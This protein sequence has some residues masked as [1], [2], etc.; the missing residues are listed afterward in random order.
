MLLFLGFACAFAPPTRPV[1]LLVLNSYSPDSIAP[2]PFNEVAVPALKRKLGQSVEVYNEYLEL[3]RFPEEEHRRTLAETLRGRYRE[4]GI[5]IVVP[6]DFAALEFARQYMDEILPK[7]PV[8][9]V[10]VEARLIRGMTFPDNMTGVVHADDWRGTL[11]EILRMQPDTKEV[12]VVGGSAPIDHEYLEEQKRLFQ[13]YQSKVKFS[14]FTDLPLLEILDKVSKLPPHTVVIQSG[15]NWDSRGEALTDDGALKLIYQAAN[16]PVYALVGRNLGDGFV[17]GPVP[18]YRERYLLGADLIYRVLKGEQPAKI[19]IQFAVPEHAMAFDWRQLKRWGISEERLPAGSVVEF[20]EPSPWR[21]YRWLIALAILV[22]LAEAALIVGL[23]LQR[24]WGRRMQEALVTSRNEIRELAGR[25]IVAQEDERKRIA[26]ELH[27]DLSQQLAAVAIF[28]S[29]I[30]RDLST[31]IPKDYGKL[32]DLRGR[33]GLLHDGIHQLSHEL[34]PATLENAGLDAALR[35]QADE[36]NRLTGMIVHVDTRF[37]PKA[38]S[39]AVA[40]CFYRVAQE[41]LHNAAKHSGARRAEVTVAHVSDDLELAVKDSGRGFD[42]KA[43]RHNSGLGLTSMGER[44]RLV[45][46]TLHIESTPQGGTT[47]RARVPCAPPVPLAMK[48]TARSL[49]A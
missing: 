31:L 39:P 27:D 23:L 48:A 2:T 47:V 10:S 16:A 5:D 18:A 8:V 12:V 33:L 7:A 6:V 34:H 29:S 22:F 3:Q 43:R 38:I 24:S 45:G 21:Q 42:P 40:L 15:F 44:V 1:R 49:R 11:G 20:R 14:Y 41:A 32:D 36:L 30:R 4:R 25:L 46:G 13:P 28:V 35:Q 19:P 37:E 26:R 9:F 17:G